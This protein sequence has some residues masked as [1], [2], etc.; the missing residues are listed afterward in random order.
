MV[1]MYGEIFGN[2]TH[3]MYVPCSGNL[4]IGMWSSPAV[5]IASVS[6]SPS[7][8]WSA[9][10]NANYGGALL[11]QIFY[12]QG[13]NCNSTLTMTPIYTG[14]SSGGLNFLVMMDVVG[15]SDYRPRRGCNKHR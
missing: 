6:S 9:G 8:T 13:M 11:A 10:A 15:A 4:L 7:G 12:G 2:S 14:P 5:T 1:N 3:T